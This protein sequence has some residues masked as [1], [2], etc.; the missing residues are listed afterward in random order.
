MNKYKRIVLK[1]SGEVFGSEGVKTESYRKIAQTI[2]GIKKENE[3]ELGIVVGGGNIFRGRERDVQFDRVQADNIGM[4]ATIINGL[5]LEEALKDLGLEAV[6]MT[7]IKMNSMAEPFIAKRAIEHLEKGRIV[8]FGGGT[9][10]PFF[11]TDTAAALRACEISADAIL[12]ATNVDGVYDKDPDEHKDAKLYEKISYEEAMEKNLKV[13]DS[14][15][16]ALCRDE[17]KPIIV[18]NVKDLEKVL[19]GEESG[20]LVS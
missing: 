3:L 10:N 2:A 12:K 11:S 19:R 5:G 6:M 20:T 7:A 17:K 14:T 18:F 13:M 1:L 16:F 4:L 15:A 8:I 9:G